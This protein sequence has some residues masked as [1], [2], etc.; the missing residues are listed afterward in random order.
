MNSQPLINT[1]DVSN[2][3]TPKAVIHRKRASQLENDYGYPSVHNAFK[4][5]RDDK[6]TNCRNP[7]HLVLFAKNG[8]YRYNICNYK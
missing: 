8:Y 5:Y 2:L 3:P 4:Q 6:N 1:E 7:T